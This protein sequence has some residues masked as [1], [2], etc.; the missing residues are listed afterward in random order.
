MQSGRIIGLMLRGEKMT[1]NSKMPGKKKI[2][3]LVA[4]G[5]LIF[6]GL[7]GITHLPQ[8][9]ASPSIA[10]S[11]G[12]RSLSPIPINPTN[13]KTQGLP[14]DMYIR[15]Y[16]LPLDIGSIVNNS[17]SNLLSNTIQIVSE[18]FRG[19]V[20]LTLNAINTAVGGILSL[21]GVPFSNWSVD[22]SHQ[23]LIIPIIFVGILGLAGL[24]LYAYFIVYGFMGD[25]RGGEEDIGHE[26]ENIEEME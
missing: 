9:H 10:I 24:I 23:G 16:G 18:F 3:I 26:E 5:V 14:L 2:L 22:V 4:I 19:L 1:W 15:T 21:F 12:E 11:N 13:I 20:N 8:A 6:S 17:L 25:I 7:A